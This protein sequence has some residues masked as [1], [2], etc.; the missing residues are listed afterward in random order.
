MIRVFGHSKIFLVSSVVFIFLAVVLSHAD[1]NGQSRMIEGVP[2][3]E[4]E[5][6]QCGPAS[7][8]GVINFYGVKVTPEE[9]ARLIFSSSA[10][11]TLDIDM[12]L[13]AERNGFQARQY[14]GSP[15][16]LKK[17]IDSG[18]PPIVLVDYGF[19]V[20]QRNH[21]MVVIG[22]SDD[23]IIVH[24]GK[25]KGKIISYEDLKGP[26]ERAGFWT[27]IITPERKK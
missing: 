12:V 1:L 16:D 9:I 6:N 27:L 24:S 20:Y 7:L 13:Y 8:A 14:R 23:G 5:G 26:W 2:F 17:N 22:Y 11:G 19:F 25:D 4:Q 10:R 18:H 21:Y 3:Y 15:I